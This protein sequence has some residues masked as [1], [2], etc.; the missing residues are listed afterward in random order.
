MEEVRSDIRWSGG[1]RK[2]GKGDA[3]TENFVKLEIEEGI[4]EERK[5]RI[6]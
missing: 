2:I 1:D 5:I 3:K 6:M 4:R